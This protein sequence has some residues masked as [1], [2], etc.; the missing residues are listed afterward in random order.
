MKFMPL[1][2]LIVLCISSRGTFFQSLQ[3]I[4]GLFVLYCLIRVCIVCTLHLF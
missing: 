1:D 2:F 4:Q 3:Q